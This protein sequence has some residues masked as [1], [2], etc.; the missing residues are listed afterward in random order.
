[1]LKSILRFIYRKL[2]I[3]FRDKQSDKRIKFI[4]DTCINFD[5]IDEEVRIYYVQNKLGILAKNGFDFIVLKY[6]RPFY[7]NFNKPKDVW[8][9]DQSYFHILFEGGASYEGVR[10]IIFNPLGWRDP[11]GY[12][13]YPNMQLLI[14]IMFKIRRLE[15]KYCNV[16][17]LY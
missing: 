11:I 17:N 12:L 16:K 3:P 2:N 9:D 1:M 7:Y 14:D 13:Y 8:K 5:T 10:S 15:K 4:I 6:E